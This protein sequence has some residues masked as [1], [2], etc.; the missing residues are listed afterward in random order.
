MQHGS[1][2]SVEAV[3]EAYQVEMLELLK[4][5]G[6]PENVVGWYHSHPGFGVW[7][8]GVDCNTQVSFE[9]LNPR[10]V[11]ILSVHFPNFVDFCSVC[12]RWQWSL[13]PFRV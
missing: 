13:I 1:G 3:D 9:K 12:Y 2:V 8:S 4:L 5:T 10:C 11:S 6:R 7:M